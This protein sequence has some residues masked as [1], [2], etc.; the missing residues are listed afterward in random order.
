MTAE[1][2]PG[3]SIDAA[4]ALRAESPSDAIQIPFV[5]H[6]NMLRLGV[7]APETGVATITS[8]HRCSVCCSAAS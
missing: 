8:N 7:E 5:R 3:V 1:S 4:F 6:Q 2:W